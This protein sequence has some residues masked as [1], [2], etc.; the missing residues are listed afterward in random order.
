M[1]VLKD[2]GLPCFVPYGAFYIFP[3]IT[4][5]GLTSEEFTNCRSKK[6]KRL[7]CPD[8]PSERAERALSVFYAYS[9]EELKEAFEHI[10]S[11][12]ERLRAEKSNQ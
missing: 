8:R 12:I 7:L 11:F 9:I 5:F 10:K 4:E 2:L 6:R 3:N 1:K